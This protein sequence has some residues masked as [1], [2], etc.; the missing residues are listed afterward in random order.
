MI[1]ETRLT[2]LQ[3]G[4]KDSKPA[5]TGQEVVD[6]SIDDEAKA[7]SAKRNLKRLKKTLDQNQSLI[8]A[9]AIEAGL[10]KM[11][12]TM[13]EEEL[14][15]DVTI[16]QGIVKG[17]TA[18]ALS[19]TEAT[20]KM[21]RL[22]FHLYKVVGVVGQSMEKF[23]KEMKKRKANGESWES[24]DDVL[25]Y[26]ALCCE[27][28]SQ[29]AKIKTQKPWLKTDL[30]HV[31]VLEALKVD[32]ENDNIAF[33][34]TNALYHMAKD[35]P[36]VNTEFLEAMNAAGA[37]GVLNDLLMMQPDNDEL[38]AHVQLLLSCFE[39]LLANEETYLS[40]SGTLK[41]KANK[42]VDRDNGANLFGVFSGSPM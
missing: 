40:T 2:F 16:H 39:A 41:S 3:M 5:E 19:V 17:I 33:W 11:V 12:E 25:E 38:K 30:M 6:T 31:Y 21:A 29:I 37:R 8:V 35:G 32:L 9:R 18:K 10:H 36:D 26:L 14:A 15:S 28:F 7:S 4:N 13:L 24:E 27:S 22:D 42:I 20:E 1:V 23:A 34:G